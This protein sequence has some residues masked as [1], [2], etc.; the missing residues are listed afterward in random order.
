MIF[1]RNW[2]LIFNKLKGNT[3]TQRVNRTADALN[4]KLFNG[5]I[6]HFLNYMQLLGHYMNDL[7]LQRDLCRILPASIFQKNTRLQN[8]LPNIKKTAPK[9]DEKLVKEITTLIENEFAIMS[10]S[11]NFIVIYRFLKKI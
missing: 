5:K 6:I 8:T 1:I 11:N 7:N 2:Y 10:D 9:I 4:F 3:W